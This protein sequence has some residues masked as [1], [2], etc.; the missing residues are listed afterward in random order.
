MKIYYYILIISI[1]T[2]TLLIPDKVSQFDSNYQ[3]ILVLISLLNA[4]IFFKF[5]NNF[6]K[7]FLRFDVLFIIT[8]FIVHFQI[9]IINYFGIPPKRGM[10]IWIN[11]NAVNYATWLSAI[12]LNI[13][14][15]GYYMY[16][17][18]WVLRTKPKKKYLI[19]FQYLDISITLLFLLFI[20]LVG[21]SFLSGS[22]NGV[23]NWGAGAV[24]IN[25]ILKYLLALR[26]IYFWIN[27]DHIFSINT[28]NNNKLFFINL[29]SYAILFLSVG[30]R[31]P[32]LYLA[33]VFLG[34]YS[35]FQHHINLKKLIV[36]LII[37]SFAFT[38]IGLGRSQDSS[39]INQNIVEVG[40]TA[41]TKNE[42]NTNNTDELASSIRILYRA[43]DVVPAKHPYLYGVPMT[44]SIIGII[45][46]GGSFVLNLVDLPKYYSSTPLFFTYL[47]QGNNVSYGEGSELI[48]DLY[49][50]LGTTGVIIVMFIFGYIISIFTNEVF[51]KESYKYKIVYIVLLFF[52][53]Y[54][55]RDFL[56]SILKPIIWILVF[57][58]FYSKKHIIY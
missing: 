46:F 30:S 36:L 52:A 32:I 16:S 6:I 13:W 56:F 51:F 33:I 14:F 7:S 29:L 17:S 42:N 24:Y 18:K 40:Y 41:Y 10:L 54:I 31:S 48:A 3:M 37:S 53:I 19:Q 22:Y 35:V 50:N 2:L 28:L 5:N 4:L 11:L 57:D 25:M 20:Y 1:L 44:L 12:S 43:I 9:I 58:Y 15:L 39:T 23:S 8:F 38:I 27:N 21:K 55:N 26:I 45:P 47:G 49:V 34:S